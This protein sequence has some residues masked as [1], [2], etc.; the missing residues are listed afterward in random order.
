VGAGILAVAFAGIGCGGGDSSSG[1]TISKAAFVKKADAVCQ[2]GNSRME[3]AFAHFLEENKN[4]KKP[5]E[6]ESE[7][8]V[9]K[10]IVPNL[11]REIKELRALG[12]PSDDEDRVDAFISAV[13]EGLETAE[14]NPQ[15]AVSSSSE[16]IFGI[17]SRLAKE[18][19][20]EVCGSR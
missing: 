1:P 20:L 19:G 16:A 2:G 17:S 3:V 7:K 14:G 5:S 8:L 10:V 15:A 6:A 4:V 13:E 9:G 18:Y 11:K 12:V